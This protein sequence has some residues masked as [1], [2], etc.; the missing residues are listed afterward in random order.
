M[1]RT[2]FLRFAAE[3]EVMAKFSPSPE[4]RA[5]WSTLAQRWIRC[6]KLIDQQR[7]EMI[8]AAAR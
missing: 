6:A 5:V 3:C 1:D 4:S 7:F 8:T 2:R